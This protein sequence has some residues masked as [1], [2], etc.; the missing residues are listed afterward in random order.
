VIGFQELIELTALQEL[1]QICT[2][3]HLTLLGP[4]I[5]C[6]NPVLMVV[7]TTILGLVVIIQ[8][9]VVIIQDQVIIITN[10]LE[11]QIILVQ[12]TLDRVLDIAQ[13]QVH[14]FQEVVE[15]RQDQVH[16]EVVN[17]EDNF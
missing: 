2:I 3:N 7:V 6:L 17:L 10:R 12:V 4:Q 5:A 16:L 13:H 8:N 14:H 15:C 1:I 11:A 9:Q